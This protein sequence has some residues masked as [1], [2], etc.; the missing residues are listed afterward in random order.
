MANILLRR[1]YEDTDKHT[2]KVT[3]NLGKIVI[4]EPKGNIFIETSPASFCP[5]L[6]TR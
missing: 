3:K 4:Y 6:V 1:E 2:G 5:R